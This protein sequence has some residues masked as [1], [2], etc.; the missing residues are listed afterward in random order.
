MEG[1]SSSFGTSGIPP[2]FYPSAASAPPPEAFEEPKQQTFNDVSSSQDDKNSREEEHPSMGDKNVKGQ[3]DIQ[4]TQTSNCEISLKEQDESTNLLKD[5][6]GKKETLTS[7]G[8]ASKVMVTEYVDE[9]DQR[10]GIAL[11]PR[12]QGYKVFLP[13]RVDSILKCKFQPLVGNLGNVQGSD[14]E[15]E[16][17]KPRDIAYFPYF[18]LFIIIVQATMLGIMIWRSGGLESPKVNPLIGPSGISFLQPEFLSV[19]HETLLSFVVQTMLEFQAKYAP[20]VVDEYQ[21]WRFI[22][23]LILHAG[24][25]HFVWNLGELKLPFVIY[26][27]KSLHYIYD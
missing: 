4:K 7:Y 2:L 26:R 21:F 13:N 6:R 18:T 11:N 24:L 25:I 1:T 20:D 12:K 23:P 19:P 17:E 8:S 9:E 5:D 27:G 16:E 3:E 22:V 14:Y 10:P 15:E